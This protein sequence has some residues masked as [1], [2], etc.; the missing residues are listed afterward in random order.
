MPPPHRHLPDAVLLQLHLADAVLLR[1]HLADAVL[2]QLL[3]VAAHLFRHQHHMMA[4]PF[5]QKEILVRIACKF[6]ELKTTVL[7]AHGQLPKR[8]SRVSLRS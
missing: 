7:R 5:G 2:L 1:L 3:A 6:V 4:P 8:A